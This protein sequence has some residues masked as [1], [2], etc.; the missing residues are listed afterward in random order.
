MLHEHAR[1]REVAVSDLRSLP[2]H[3][4]SDVED[5]ARRIGAEKLI[6]IGWV[7]EDLQ[8]ARLVASKISE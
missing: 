8:F 6:L 5:L 3:C 7:R 1:E 4:A 2:D